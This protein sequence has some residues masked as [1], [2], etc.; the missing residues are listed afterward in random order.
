MYTFSRIG[1]C[2]MVCMVWMYSE[3]V[4]IDLIDKYSLLV[5]HWIV[6]PFDPWLGLML[7][8]R[9]STGIGGEWTFISKEF[10]YLLFYWSE[11]SIK[12]MECTKIWN[13]HGENNELQKV[14][15]FLVNS[16]SYK[17]RFLNKLLYLGKYHRFYS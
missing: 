12:N 8:D 3:S 14:F 6:V 7:M 5:L 4:L 10:L 9:G 2:M 17:I 1:Y 16:I 11:Y 15:C 13:D